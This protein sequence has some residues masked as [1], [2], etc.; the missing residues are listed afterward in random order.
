LQHTLNE[1]GFPI[2]INISAPGEIVGV[3]FMYKTILTEFFGAKEIYNI[4]TEIMENINLLHLRNSVVISSR[5]RYRLNDKFLLYKTILMKK[6]S[7]AI[8]LPT[9]FYKGVIPGILL[10]KHL[11]ANWLTFLSATRRA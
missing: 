5:C 3:I 1:T 11:L 8:W 6:A 9:L 10:Y 2:Q 7:V 4:T